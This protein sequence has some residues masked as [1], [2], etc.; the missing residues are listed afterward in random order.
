VLQAEK[1]D[2]TGDYVRQWVP[3]LA[4]LEAPGIHSPWAASGEALAH[5]GVSLGKTYPKPIVDHPAARARAL[6]AFA[7]M[8]GR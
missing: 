4:G 3:E 5:A 2:P 8:R 1:F 6:D 7:R